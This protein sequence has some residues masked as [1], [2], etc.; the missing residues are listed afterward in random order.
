MYK[1]AT[2]GIN[3]KMYQAIS[4][5]YSNPRSRVILNEY[6]TD[7]FDCPIGV[8]QGD[9]LSPTLFAI[10]INDL[11]S[12][13]K[14]LNLGLDLNI[15]G[16]PDMSYIFSIL[17]YAD[18]IVCLAENEHDLQAILFLVENWC[19][20]W[21][22]EVNLTKTNILHVR[23]HRKQQSRFTFL[24]DM[25]PVS[26]CK[27]YKYLGVNINEYLDF[28]FTVE[29]H[30]DSAG[31][32]L[33]A[34]ITKMIKNGGF[35]YNVYSLLY[36]ACVTSVSDYSGPITG[37]QEYDSALK[38]HLRAIRAFI[39]VPKNACSVGILS[40]VDLLL[41]HYRTKLQMV[42]QYH[43]MVCMQDSK[44]TKQIFTWDRL[45]NERN[46]V[47]SWSNEIR[48][49]FSNCNLP[50]IFESNN[51]FNIQEVIPAMKEYFKL[52]QSEH[53]SLECTQKPKLRTFML[54]KMFQEQPAY[55]SKPLTF[56]Q[57]RSIA[58]TRL[59]CLP[60]RLETGRY[61]IPRLPEE[62]R[63]CLVCKPP[64]LPQLVV[65]DPP[66]DPE[67]AQV[68]PVETE[69][70]FL[71]SCVAYNVERVL[72]FSKMNLPI[73][74]ETLPLESKLKTVLNDPSNVKATSTFITNSFNA[75][76][77]ILK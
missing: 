10:F 17:L 75:R 60:V 68:L 5:L 53:L 29:K 55:I 45:L 74:F 42:R 43:R 20:K 44:L 57:R 65:V 69:A 30:S 25:R 62:E 38:I 27:Y 54:F 26:Y 6:E 3:G 7:Y 51:P 23:N 72:W 73:D 33:G 40:E 70:H 9:C 21:R 61:S 71:F 46:I 24:F 49:I 28:K 32:A 39:G 2:N 67:P 52:K 36:N 12:E 35:P 48:D 8:K 64:N 15:E 47:N 4:S 1:L 50:T 22:L 37:Y 56:H 59:G 11:A 41:P 13:I 31:R 66:S 34:I 63:V 16:G 14:D 19:K 77:K 18:D 58:K 76:S